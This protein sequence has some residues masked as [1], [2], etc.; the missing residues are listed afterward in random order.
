[1]KL[2]VPMDDCFYNYDNV[3]SAQPPMLWELCHGYPYINPCDTHSQEY[4]CLMRYV[5]WAF[6]EKP[7]F[8]QVSIKFRC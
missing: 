6:R 7:R 2:E 8:T 5:H 3:G 4:Y 1:M